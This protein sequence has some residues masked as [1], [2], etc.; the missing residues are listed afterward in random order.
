M[1]LTVRLIVGTGVPYPLS[2]GCTTIVAG[3][4]YKFLDRCLGS[5]LIAEQFEDAAGAGRLPE[6]RPKDADALVPTGRAHIADRSRRSSNNIVFALF[7]FLSK[8]LRR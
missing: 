3:E 5:S 7:V 8:K 1:V 6:D 2:A 4:L